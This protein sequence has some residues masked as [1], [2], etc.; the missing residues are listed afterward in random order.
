MLPHPARKFGTRFLTTACQQYWET[1]R[2]TPPVLVEGQERILAMLPPFHIYA[3]TVNVLF[4]ILCGAEII[5]HVRFDPKA[6]LEEISRKKTSVF[7]GVPKMFTAL[8]NDPETP[9]H[10]L[11]SLKPVYDS[12]TVPKRTMAPPKGKIF[13]VTSCTTAATML[14]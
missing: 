13:D 7:C 6:A 11:R 8:I 2:G 3:L 4:G 12:W 5:Q 1:A 9:N 14:S 10:S